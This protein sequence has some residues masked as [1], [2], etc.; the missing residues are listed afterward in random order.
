MSRFFLLLILGLCLPYIAS[1]LSKYVFNTGIHDRSGY[2]NGDEDGSVSHESSEETESTSYG[3]EDFSSSSISD[4]NIENRKSTSE[5]TSEESA[6][7]SKSCEKPRESCQDPSGKSGLYIS[8]GAV[9]TDDTVLKPPSS[10]C[11]CETGSRQFFTSV[12][13]STTTIRLAITNKEISYALDSSDAACPELCIRDDKNQF[14]IP[15]KDSVAYIASRCIGTYCYNDMGLESGELTRVGG[16]E[17]FT[18]TTA[19]IDSAQ[20]GGGGTYMKVEAISCQGCEWISKEET[21]KCF[22]RPT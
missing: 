4:E 15:T 13:S 2:G 17:T 9:N 1:E 11:D 22:A 8:N 10:I 14:W 6:S 20:I 18:D 21:S 16:T 12:S 7:D 19:D 3:D 5:S